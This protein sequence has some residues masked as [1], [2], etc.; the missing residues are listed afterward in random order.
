MYHAKSQAILLFHMWKVE[1]SCSR[2]LLLEALSCFPGTY[3]SEY[4]AVDPC[5]HAH[6]S[7]VGCSFTYFT[8]THSHRAWLK[9]TGDGI[10]PVAVWAVLELL[11]KLIAVI[12]SNHN[13]PT[14]A[15]FHCCCPWP[16]LWNPVLLPSRFTELL[17]EQMHYLHIWFL[18]LQWKRTLCMWWHCQINQ[19]FLCEVE[20]CHLILRLS[21]EANQGVSSLQGEPTWFRRCFFLRTNNSSARTMPGLVS[22]ALHS[23]LCFPNGPCT[24]KHTICSGAISFIPLAACCVH[25]ILCWQIARQPSCYFRY[26]NW[27]IWKSKQLFLRGRRM[28]WESGTGLRAVILPAQPRSLFTAWPGAQ[29]CLAE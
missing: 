26:S 4:T 29:G 19:M 16:L 24:L 13:F 10:S 2:A 18:Q 17:A 15:Q 9:A 6:I 25:T 14:A 1:S 12:P 28:A 21:G 3:V 27:N 23:P 11:V 20:I 5:T 8:Y 22:S 7:Q